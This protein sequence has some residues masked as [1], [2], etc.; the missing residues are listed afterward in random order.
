MS[1]PTTKPRLTLRAIEKAYGTEDACK[2][3]LMS[4]RWP[5][6]KPVCPRC[7]ESTRVYKTADRFRWKCKACNKNGYKF[8]VLTGTVF[9]NTNMPLTIWFRVALLMVSSKKG[10]SAL[11]IWRMMPPCRGEQGS[12]KT[13]WYMCMRI[14]AAM[15][16]VEGFKKLAGIVEI[17]ETYVGGKSGNKHVGKRHGG[18][19]T[20]FKGKV[21][22]I[23]AVSRK[24]NVTARIID[25]LDVPTVAKFVKETVSD[26]L[27]LVATDNSH[28]YDGVQWGVLRRHESVDHSKDE[29]V[30]GI[31]HTATIDS[32]WSLLKRGIMG[33]FHHV[34]KDYLPLYINEFSWRYN[35]RNN[36][37]IFRA[38]L[39]GC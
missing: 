3:L 35:N 22:V 8:S 17:D 34:S 11:Q 5:D 6:G 14:R 1:K 13:F 33:S 28:I 32:F 27:T 39:A 26:S 9:E 4:L 19:N 18:A 23:G 16:D 12:Y 38:V 10:M 7:A 30:R 36:P 15:Q 37:D 25:K 2:A 20:P 31:V 21:G 24:G 29:Y